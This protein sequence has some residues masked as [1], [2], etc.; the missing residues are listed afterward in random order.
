M[1]R[2]LLISPIGA[3]VLTLFL[4]ACGSQP[5]LKVQAVPEKIARQQCF[6]TSSE[7]FIWLENENQWLEL[8]GKARQEFDQAEI[9]WELDNVFIVSAGQKNSAGY[10]IEL[11]NWL[12]EESHWQVTLIHHSPQA[13]SL[14]AQMISSPCVLIKIPKT[15]KSFALNNAQGSALGHWPY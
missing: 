12:L 1:K 8:P 3:L 7:S 6:I 2:Y 5:E 9:D 10:R 15:V 14:Q 13:G 11:T 4:S